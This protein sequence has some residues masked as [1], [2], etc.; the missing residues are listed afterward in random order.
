VI[1]VIQFLA[2]LFSLF[3]LSRV[4]LRA[5]DK[6]ITSGELVFWLGI[7]I[8]LIVVIIFPEIS[9][10]FATFLGIGRGTDAILYASIGILFYIVFR[11]YVKLEETQKELTKIVRERAIKNKKK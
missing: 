3:A 1:S 8:I 7:W 9:S 10:F 6:K 11:L 4:I 5:K 2:L